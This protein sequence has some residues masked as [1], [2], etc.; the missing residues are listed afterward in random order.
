MPCW[1]YAASVQGTVLGIAVDLSILLYLLRPF[2]SPHRVG[3]PGRLVPVG[4]DCASRRRAVSKGSVHPR[5]K[6]R[7]GVGGGVWSGLPGGEAGRSRKRA[8]FLL[9]EAFRSEIGS[10]FWPVVL[11]IWAGP[12]VARRSQHRLLG[13]AFAGKPVHEG[14]RVYESDTDCFREAT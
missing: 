3:V 1:Y 14:S 2:P 13:R 4:S 9:R 12:G 5:S 6:T 8:L 11:D 10:P 7:V